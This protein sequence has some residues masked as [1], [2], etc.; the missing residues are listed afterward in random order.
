[1][2]RPTA[3]FIPY[4]LLLGTLLG[5]AAFANDTTRYFL[6][7][8]DFVQIVRQ[9]HPVA[10]QA[11]LLKDQAKAEMLL[12][13]G[14]WDPKI[15]SDYDE[16]MF[17][18]THY[19]SYFENKISVPIWYG[20]EAKAGYNTATG[21]YLNSE[22]MLPDVGQGFVGISLPL[23]KNLLIDKQRAMLRQAQLFRE[24]SEQQRLM[25]LND[26][27]VAGLKCYYDWAYAYSEMKVFEEATRIN[28][29]RFNAMVESVKL[30][31][32]AAIDTTEA[33]TQLQGRQ[34]QLN[35]ARLKFIKAGLDLNTYLWLEN[36]TPRPL[37]SLLLP[38][39]LNSD[40]LRVQLR[41]EKL[42]ELAAE[43]LQTHPI[44]RNYD[45]KLR[46]LDIERRLKIE[47]MKPTLNL[48]YNLLNESY[49]VRNDFNYMVNNNY[50]LGLNFSMPLFFMQGRGDLQTTKLKI[51]NTQYAVE[52]KKLELVNKL[53]AY[54]NE[55][56]TLQAQTKL[57]EKNIKGFAQL[58]EGET[59]RLRNG[60]SSL[61]LVNAR[62]NRFLESQV[63]LYELQSKFYKTE[64]DLKWTL[65]DIGR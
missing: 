39:P 21:K 64:A 9:Y 53:K 58:F 7:V 60:E 34:F 62:E 28:V 30:G 15:Y 57:Y 54:Y 10:K 32:R 38:S 51:K 22:S 50:K 13:Y 63:K 19:Y 17:E 44:L 5:K 47:S 33:L 65:G 41:Y 4:F 29:V 27:L 6:S 12:A 35:E 16:K 42:E 37:D 23:M 25:M 56:M 52:T 11:Q 48:N 20:I 46:Q 59:A 45:F 43:L 14:G 36:E 61:F 31:D 55:M 2:R 8:V 3:V 1:V 26:L 40:F 49:R 18:G 24:A